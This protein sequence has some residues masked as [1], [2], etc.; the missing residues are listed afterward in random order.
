M[1]NKK[2]GPDSRGR[3]SCLI[4]VPFFSQ[5][6][7]FRVGWFSIAILAVYRCYTT[8]KTIV[9]SSFF[10][11]HW[12]SLRPPN[13]VSSFSIL[14]SIYPHTLTLTLTTETPINRA[15]QAESE[16]VRVEKEK[17]YFYFSSFFVSLFP[18]CRYAMS[19]LSRI[20]V[21]QAMA[22]P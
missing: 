5:V 4:Q 14:H 22:I 15:F 1:Q 9:N 18:V 20:P 2:C 6:S 10:I 7:L 17:K 13:V 16:G 21:R 8:Q 3:I 12:L 19:I 11:L